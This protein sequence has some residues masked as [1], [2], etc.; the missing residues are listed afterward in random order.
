MHHIIKVPKNHYM[1]IR[2][3]SELTVFKFN[4]LPVLFSPP[5]KTVFKTF[6]SILYIINGFHS[7][8]SNSPNGQWIQK[9]CNSRD[10]KLV[11]NSENYSF[12][13]K[14]KILKTCLMQH[15]I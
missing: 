3:T 12:Y 4:G 14:K 13:K 15:C 9:S 8:L 10:I 5:A 11:L 6:H 1:I 2:R 7:W